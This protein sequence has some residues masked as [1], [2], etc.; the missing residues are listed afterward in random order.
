MANN[1]ST[2]LTHETLPDLNNCF[3]FFDIRKILRRN[4]LLLVDGNLLFCLTPIF[5]FSAHFFPSILLIV[6]STEKI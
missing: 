4:L 2:E 3:Y 5:S 1:Q 6:Y